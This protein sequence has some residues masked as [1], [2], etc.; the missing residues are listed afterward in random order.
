MINWKTV[1]KGGSKIWTVVLT[2]PDGWNSSENTLTWKMLTA[3]DATPT[4]VAVAITAG[5]AAITT[6]TNT[7]DTL[8]LTFTLSTVNSDTLT[9]GRYVV[10]LESAAADGTAER[11]W[12]EAAGNFT[13]RE[14]YG[15][16]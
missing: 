2:N 13:V 6:V 11:Y 4:T 10:E 14:P 1:V 9:A 7:N 8:T 12:D 5:A 3:S 16:G 15:G